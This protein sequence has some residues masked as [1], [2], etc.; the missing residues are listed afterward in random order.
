M[1]DQI[2]ER[3]GKQAGIP[4]GEFAALAKTGAA[5]FAGA[6]PYLDRRLQGLARGLPVPQDLSGQGGLVGARS[7]RDDA[8]PV[9]QGDRSGRRRRCRCAAVSSLN[10]LVT[11]ASMIERESRLDSERPLVSSVIYN[12][13]TNRLVPQDRRDHSVRPGQQPA[14]SDQPGHSRSTRRTTPTRT[15]ACH[16]DRSRTRGSSRSRP[17][18]QPA[19]TQLLYYVL[20]GKDGSHTFTTNLA[21]FL[22]AK[23]KSKQVFG[24]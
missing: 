14:P 19:E 18:P 13:L 20:T 11:L 16:P 12:R 23:R 8:R 2:A 22:A 5:Q 6:H 7:H 17:Q 21:D 9:R 4:T 1:I 3:F 24:E 10:Q 15:R